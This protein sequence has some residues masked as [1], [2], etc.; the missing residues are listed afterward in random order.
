EDTRYV[1]DVLA[2]VAAETRAAARQAADLIEVEYAVLDPVTDPV[3]AMR[4]EAPPIHADGNVLSVSRVK[5]GD[6]EAAI[7]TAAHVATET[8]RTQFLAHAFPAP[9]SS[10]VAP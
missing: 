4:P 2:A 5:R 9:Q 7:A 8:F 6:V 1:G 3:E 10:P